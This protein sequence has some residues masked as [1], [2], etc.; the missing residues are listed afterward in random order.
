[1]TRII[2]SSLILGLLASILLW[3]SAKNQASIEELMQKERAWQTQYLGF[4]L[5]NKVDSVLRNIQNN[6]LYLPIA[7]TPESSLTYSEGSTDEE[8]RQAGIRVS[9]KPYFQALFA[10]I[11][12]AIGR[13]L[14][15]GLLSLSLLPFLGATIVDG[16]C[17][18]EVRYARFK[19][20]SSLQF[21][22]AGVTLFIVIELICL[23]SLIPLWID[24][25]VILGG[26]LLLAVCIQRLITHYYR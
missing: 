12:L 24:P 20:S 19:P 2:Y 17:E 23:I 8:M 1:M 26:I 18:R 7:H 11:V 22:A 21:R 10:L 13:M 25:L 16:L 14:V 9:Q 15:T 5:V 4:D 3:P 6:M